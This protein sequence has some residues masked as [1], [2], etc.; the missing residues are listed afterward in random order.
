MAF[1]SS[2]ATLFYLSVASKELVLVNSNTQQDFPTVCVYN[3]H[4]HK[5]QSL[6]LL[7]VA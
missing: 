2:N 3:I 1:N 4:D 7:I 6:L 5:E